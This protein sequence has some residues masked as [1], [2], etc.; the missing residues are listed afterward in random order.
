MG[1]T[2]LIID[3]SPTMRKMVKFSMKT[4]MGFNKQL[5]AGD[6]LEAIDVLTHNHV[7]L[8]ICDV[9]MPNMNGLDFLDTIKKDE[10][11]KNIPIIMLTTEGGINDK[12]QAFDLGADGYVVK[13]F[14]P[15]LLIKEI[16]RVMQIN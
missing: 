16:K 12:E 4:M 14:R 8:I 3:D 11:F 5:E 10:E 6:G 15:P 1:K 9:N 7:D 13:P 2:V